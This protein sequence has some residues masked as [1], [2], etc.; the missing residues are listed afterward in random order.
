TAHELERLGPDHHLT[1]PNSVVEML[2][3]S[4]GEPEGGWP[5]RIQEVVLRSEKPKTGRPGE[6]LAPV[7]FAAASE[8]LEKQTGRKPS[9]TDLLS[10]L[11][12]PEVFLK[13]SGAR[14]AYGSLDVLPTPQFFYGLD[15]G[16]EVTVEIE[17][18][19]VLIVKFLAVSDPQPDGMRTIF[20]ELNG[21]P[22]EVTIRDRSL[23]AAAASRRQADLAIPGQV[24]APFPGAISSVSVEL[25]QRV[26]KGGRLLVMEAMKMQ[27]TVYAPISGTIAE[28]LVSAGDK[29]N[30]K[31]LLIV[32]A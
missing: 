29:V 27:S 6:H 4:L 28:K 25:G 20:F 11:M 14:A 5:K 24:G 13:F 22:R 26:E 30:A 2:S 32:I 15:R 23:E 7:D 9:R 16:E 19:K 17:P 8:S 18:G 1:L 3:G 31:D 12:Y 10:Y 21:Q